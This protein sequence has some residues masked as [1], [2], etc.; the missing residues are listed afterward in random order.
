[1]MKIAVYEVRNDERNKLKEIEKNNK[2]ELIL[3]EEVLDKSTLKLAKNCVGV[4][5]LGHSE[6]DKKLLQGLKELGVHYISTRTIGFNHIDVKAGKEMGLRICN[7]CYP[8]QGVAEFTV[9]LMLLTLRNYKPAMWRQNVNDYSLGGLAGRELGK[10]T[11]GIVGTGRIGMEV[12]KMLSG[13]GCTILAH[14]LIESEEIKKY[15]QYVSLEEIYKNA[16]VISLHIPLTHEN[17]HMIHHK[18]I[19]MMKKGVVLIN[20]A[21]GE[22]MDIKALTRGI[23]NERIGALGLDVFEKEEGIYHADRKTDIIKNRD[24]VY[25]RQFPNVVMTQHMAFYTNVNVDY[26][27]EYGIKGIIDFELTGKCEQEI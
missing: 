27:A 15:A 12:I 9:M 24:M 13:F 1:M 7:S 8:P 4:S 19:G 10:Q 26:M 5:I 20:T 17:Y 18:A 23:E 14:S 6:L 16:D 11:I 25:L 2:I 21:R 22:L 3:I